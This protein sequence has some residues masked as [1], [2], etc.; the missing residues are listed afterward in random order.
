MLAGQRHAEENRTP[1]P[2]ITNGEI[3]DGVFIEL[4]LRS[5]V[6]VFSLHAASFRGRYRLDFTRKPRI[7]VGVHV[8]VHVAAS[9]RRRHPKA[10]LADCGALVSASAMSDAQP[11]GATHM[12]NAAIVKSRNAGKPAPVERARQ[13]GNQRP[14]HKRAAAI[15]EPAKSLPQPQK[16]QGSMTD[17][18]SVV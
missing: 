2:V 11:D 15:T 3:N 14:A 12:S 8:G 13:K 10:R 7:A 1:D 17:R 18:K 9:G 16:P 4:C 6:P 5:R